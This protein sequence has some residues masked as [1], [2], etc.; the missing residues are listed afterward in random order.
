MVGVVVLAAAAVSGCYAAREIN[1]TID[2]VK[3][4]KK[5]TAK[6]SLVS[7]QEAPEAHFF[8]SII[9]E[10]SPRIKF[11][12]PRW[13]TTKVL[14]RKARP[15]VADPVLGEILA[16]SD[17]LCG[18]VAAPSLQPDLVWRTKGKQRSAGRRFVEVRLPVKVRKNAP[19]GG[20]FGFL[21]TGA[22]FDDGDKVPEDPAASDD[23]YECTS[24]ST[25]GF[26]VRGP[27]APMFEERVRALAD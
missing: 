10:H 23:F 9:G 16:E 5:T 13:D 14:N 11:Q 22:W 7:E 17:D 1:W 15:M 26:G 24:I 6:I 18:D 25:T 2:Q 27:M 12:V 20:L 21:V 8:M 3:P 4:G 19:G